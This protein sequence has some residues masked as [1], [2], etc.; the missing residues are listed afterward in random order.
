MNREA[1]LHALLAAHEIRAEA[2]CIAWGYEFIAKW[3]GRLAWDQYPLQTA[4]PQGMG[5]SPGEQQAFQ[6]QF[7]L[8][9]EERWLLVNELLPMM[10]AQCDLDLPPLVSIFSRATTILDPN[11][12]GVK[13]DYHIFIGIAETEQNHC[14]ATRGFGHAQPAF[15]YLQHVEAFHGWARAFPTPPNR[16]HCLLHR[17]Q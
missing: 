16:I 14:F 10:K 1:D 6:Q 2:S 15:I 9:T 5:W 7:N 13:R 17:L 11:A 3:H 8:I 4:H 12:I